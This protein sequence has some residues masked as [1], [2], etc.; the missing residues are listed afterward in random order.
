VT[1]RWAA[2]KLD[3][4][5]QDAVTD[6]IRQGIDS[7]EG[8]GVHS[9]RH[10]VAKANRKTPPSWRTVVG[11]GHRAADSDAAADSQ[12]GGDGW[13]RLSDGTV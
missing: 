7:L 6:G 12:L 10:S 11:L 3:R 8:N 5:R 1:T 13:P 4:Y 2:S 9:L